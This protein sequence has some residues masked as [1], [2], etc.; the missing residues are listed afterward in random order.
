MKRQSGAFGLFSPLLIFVLVLGL[1]V[2]FSCT[3]KMVVHRYYVLQIPAATD[4]LNGNKIVVSHKRC[5]LLPV[6][7]APAYAGRRIA[8]RRQSHELTYFAYHQW[9]VPLDQEMEYILNQWLTSSHLFG[10]KF[11]RASAP[12]DFQLQATVWEIEMI[13][14]KGKL[15]A[16]LHMN[17]DLLQTSTNQVVVSHRFDVIRQLP[18]QKANAFARTISAILSEELQKFGRKVRVYLKRSQIPQTVK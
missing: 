14:L 1:G 13:S 16:H 15:H 5:E 9:A 11:V 6:I 7:V 18:S 10:N 12:A 3:R 2:I 17:L 4:S 8:L